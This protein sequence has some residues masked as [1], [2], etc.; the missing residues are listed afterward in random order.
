M[1]LTRPNQPSAILALFF[2]ALLAG[3]TTQLR[4][5]DPEVAVLHMRALLEAEWI[6]HFLFSTSKSESK[7]KIRATTGR[8]V[9]AFLLA[10]G[11]PI[12]KP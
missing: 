4:Q 1:L 8:A 7:A 3:C 10:Y 9:E 12:S 5:S 2:T 6:D 11:V